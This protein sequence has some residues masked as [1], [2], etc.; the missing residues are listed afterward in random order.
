MA[1]KKYT[2]T[3]RYTDFKTHAVGTSDTTYIFDA[4][5]ITYIFHDAPLNSIMD[6]NRLSF[7]F[8]YQNKISLKFDNA[9]HATDWVNENILVPAPVC[10]CEQL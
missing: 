9:S 8:D 5:K 7:Y 2:I 6:N 4:D 3:N 1:L 10:N